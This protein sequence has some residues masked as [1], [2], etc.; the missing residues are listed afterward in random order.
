MFSNQAGQF[1]RLIGAGMTEEQVFILRDI[2]ANPK[3]T[4]NHSGVINLKSGITAP[5]IQAGR[6]AVAQHSWDYNPDKEHFTFTYPSDGGGMAVVICKEAD[7]YKGNGTT[8]NDDI[9]IY[10]P[11]GPSEDPNIEK[12]DVIM[13]FDMPDGVFVAPGYGDF[14]IGT[15]RQDINGDKGTRGW[16]VM[17]GTENAKT[18]G[19]S[20]LDLATNG[21]FLRQWPAVANNKSTGGAATDS[22]TVGSHSG[23][24]VDSAVTVAT[25]GAGTSGTGGAHT[26]TTD[27]ATLAPHAAHDH[28]IPTDNI[29]IGDGSSGTALVG[30]TALTGTRILSHAAHDHETDDPGTHTHTTPALSHTITG[31]SALSHAAVTV[32]TVPPFI[33]VA[34]LERLNNSRTGLGL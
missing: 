12:N 4:L 11:V 13:F 16:G 15:I 31:S 19:G 1:D 23:S 18:N 24:A 8:G 26:H 33:Y 2:L 9:T 32:D 3:Q 17:N 6:W 10:L 30:N 29:A 25:H 7:D 28:A 5:S 22:V 14:R 34:N 21:V 20:A 27:D